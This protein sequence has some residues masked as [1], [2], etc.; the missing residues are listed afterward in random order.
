M[1]IG[2]LVCVV[3][4]AVLIT[5]QRM[6]GVPYPDIAKSED[7]L[8]RGVLI[9]VAVGTVLLV[10]FAALTGQ[11]VPAFSQP[12]V[13]TTWLWI[14]PITMLA[15]IVLQFTRAR[16]SLFNGR[17]IAVM[18]LATLLVGFSE[19]L[20]VRGVLVEYLQDAGFDLRL[21]AVVTSVVFGLLHGLN[22]INGQSVSTTVL[23][24]ILTTLVGL[25][26]FAALMA[27]GT[28]WLPILLH[29]LMD[30][31]VIARGGV[32]NEDEE[33]PSPLQIGLT[34]LLYLGALTSLIA[35]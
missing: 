6:S 33:K 29:F 35:Y 18:I 5:L 4:A 15:L 21:V 26:L 2:L 1:L 12:R 17:A 16:W 7:N 10:L 24:V 9:P 30:F 20:L 34:G 13:E 19:E 14:V 3:Y 31:A 25:A 28:L 8:R 23:Q 32:V 11:L 27:S 22:I